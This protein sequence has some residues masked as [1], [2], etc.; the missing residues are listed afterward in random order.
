MKYPSH[1]CIFSTRYQIQLGGARVYQFLHSFILAI[2][3]I[4]QLRVILSLHCFFP[5]SLINKHHKLIPDSLFGF[6]FSFVSL[7]LWISLFTSLFFPLGGLETAPLTKN[8]YAPSLTF[9]NKSSQSATILNGLVMLGDF[10]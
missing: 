7:F 4:S 3:K 10:A 6:F 8:G 2:G 5:A 1:H 9:S